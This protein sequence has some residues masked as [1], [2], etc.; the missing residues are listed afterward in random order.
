M[1][2]I[3]TRSRKRL[4]GHKLHGDRGANFRNISKTT[5]F[6]ATLA[7]PNNEEARSLV[8]KFWSSGSFLQRKEMERLLQIIEEMDDSTVTEGAR[9]IRTDL[10]R[11]LNPTS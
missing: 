11:I 10:N 8:A 7:F 9:E 1:S 2:R 4:N 5:E 3:R 6:E